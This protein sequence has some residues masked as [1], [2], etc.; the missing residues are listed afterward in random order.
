MLRPEQVSDAIASGVN[1]KISDGHNLYLVVKNGRGFWVY[2]FRDGPVIRSKGL[3]SAATVTPAHARRA[4]EDFVGARRHGAP[5]ATA[6]LNAAVA[7]TGKTFGE[8]VADFI[9]DR[10][11]AWKGGTEGSE[12]KAYRRT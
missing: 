2:Q 4:R 3:G 9:A 12:A 5:V 10:A 11:A 6:P 8:A 1:A 7:T